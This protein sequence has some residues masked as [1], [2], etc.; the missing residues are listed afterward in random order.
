MSTETGSPRVGARIRQA[1]IRREMTLPELAQR[2]GLTKGFLS[3]VER[4]LASLSVGS[5]LRVCEALE[6]PVRELLETQQGALVR[7]AGRARIDFGGEL[8]EEFRLTPSGEQRLMVLQSVIAPGG[9]SGSEPYGLD[10]EVEFVHVLFGEL[11]IEI[12]G[13][14]YALAPGD[15]LTFEPRAERRWRNPSLVAPAGVL[16]VLVQ[17]P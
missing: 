16:W 15:S 5:L 10:I 6:L 2:S 7:A 17:A 9:G 13:D 8:L 11:H 1:R 3:Q 12:S 4:D 14:H